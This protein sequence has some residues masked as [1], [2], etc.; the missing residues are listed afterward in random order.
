[1]P[2]NNPKPVTGQKCN[3]RNSRNMLETAQLKDILEM[4]SDGDS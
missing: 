2:K 4:K 3:T 1:M